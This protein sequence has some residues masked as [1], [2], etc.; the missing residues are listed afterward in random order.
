MFRTDANLR[1]EGRSGPLT[2]TLDSYASYYEQLGADLGVPGAAQGAARRRRRGPRRAASWSVTR[3][4]VWPERPRPRRGA[5][6]PGDEGARRGRSPSARARRPRAQARAAAAS[7]TSS[8]RCSCCSSCTAATTRSVRS[9]TT[10]DALAAL[11]AGGY[12]DAADAARLDDAYRF[13]RTVEHRLQLYDEQQTHTLPADDAARTRLARVLGYREHAGAQRSSRRSRPTTG[14]TRPRCARS[15]SGCSS[16]RCSTRSRAPGPSSPDAA[17]ERLAAFGFTDV[18]RTRAAL[19]ELA[20]GLTRRSQLHAA[21]AARSSSSGC[22][23]RPIPTSAC[24]SCAA[25]PRARPDRPSLA[26]TFR[27]APGAAER[28]CRLLGSSRVVGDAPAPPPGVRRRA[29]RRRRSSRAEND[30]RRARRRRARDARVAATTPQRDASGLRRFKRRELLR[31]AQPRPARVR[32]AR[33][34]RARAHR[35]RRGVR[36]RPR[37]RRSSRRCRSR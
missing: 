20:V 33:G 6:D 24:C 1:P 17:E 4:F 29:R 37:C 12:V 7:A 25:W 3:P 31:I 11:A 32:A 19:R 34:H 10:L 35:A 36:S 18:E 13:L 14:P 28:A 9:P 15:T 22:R 30:A 8:S 23:R 21:A 16:R 2:R 5:R 27:D 26:T